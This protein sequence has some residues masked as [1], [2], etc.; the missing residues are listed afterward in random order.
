[1]LKQCIEDTVEGKPRSAQS[2][3]KKSQD[4]YKYCRQETARISQQNG[5]QGRSAGLVA[6]APKRQKKNQHL[7]PAEKAFLNFI[8]IYQKHVRIF[9]P[10]SCRF[11]PSCSE[12]AKQAILK[13]G[14]LKGSAKA[15]GRLLCCHP[16][17]G[18]AGYDPL[19]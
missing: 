16:F 17:S 12:F 7:M 3:E 9:L 4:P 15:A 6:S 1:M 11:T 10:S 8:N 19:V 18:K 5:Y 13:Y 14:F 2:Y